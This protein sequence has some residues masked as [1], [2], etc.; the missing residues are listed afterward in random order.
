MSNQAC[1]V[2]LGRYQSGQLGQTVN[3]LSDDFVGSNPA[4]PTTT[5]QRSFFQK[6]SGV[7][8]NYNKRE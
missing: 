6:K 3:L 1:A 4:L 5:V 8:V 2:V 7:P